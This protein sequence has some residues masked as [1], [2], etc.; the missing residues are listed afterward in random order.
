MKLWQLR[1]LLLGQEIAHR[2]EKASGGLKTSRNVGDMRNSN[3]YLV[4]MLSNMTWGSKRD[5]R[6]PLFSYKPLSFCITSRDTV[7]PLSVVHQ[8]VRGGE[9]DLSQEH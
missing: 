7:R 5:G 9:A 8:T 2:L 3:S 1:F 4:K 6:S